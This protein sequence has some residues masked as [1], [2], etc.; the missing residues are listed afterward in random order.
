MPKKP[1]AWSHSA[2]DSFATCPKR[3]YHVKV[4][5]DFKETFGPEADYGKMVHKAFEDYLLKNKKLPMDLQHHAK[6]LDKL[7]A[8]PGEKYGEQQLAI[9][10]EYDP[11]GWFDND[12]WSRAIIDY[13]LIHEN[14]A[15][16]FDWK[17]GKIKDDFDQLKLFILFI[18]IFRP[19]VDEFTAAY[20]WTKGK[21]FTT[22]KATRADL[23]QL[24]NELLPKVRKFE[25]AHKTTDFP[26][27][28]SGLCKRYCPV[29]TC[30][31]NG[32]YQ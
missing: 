30:P 14:K 17:T 27:K 8:A 22:F 31:H 23:P 1:I 11:T 19:E 28:E 32:G 12:V 16:I 15:K 6:I 4:K 3:H 24:W 7:K 25:I 21:Q 5:K 20:Y 26:A 9:T 13:M 29:L 2:L 10:P 18:S